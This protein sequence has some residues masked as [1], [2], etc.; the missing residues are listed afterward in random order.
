[1]IGGSIA[2]VIGAAVWA[3]I[4]YGT[5]YELKRVDRATVEETAR[6]LDDQWQ[7]NLLNLMR[8]T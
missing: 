2:G 5:N 6:T 4:A 7:A 8:T 3:A 1:V